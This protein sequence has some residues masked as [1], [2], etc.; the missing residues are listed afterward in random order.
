M[1]THRGQSIIF[2]VKNT[3]ED[4][5]FKDFGNVQMITSP[6]KHKK[7]TK[8]RNNCWN[9]F[10]KKKITHNVPKKH[11]RGDSQPPNKVHNFEKTF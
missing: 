5:P 4:Q 11:L 8:K 1:K 3:V 6:K 2:K 10:F 7:L 9:T